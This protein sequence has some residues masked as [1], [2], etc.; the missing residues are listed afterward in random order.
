MCD[1]IITLFQMQERLAARKAKRKQEQQ[2]KPED[3]SFIS[4]S[5]ICKVT[6]LVLRND[7][8]SSE[9][10]TFY[11]ASCFCA[12]KHVVEFAAWYW[13]SK[14]LAAYAASQLRWFL[15]DVMV[16][17]RAAFGQEDRS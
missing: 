14:G 2:L 3:V 15:F 8:D 6:K 1:R 13:V 5:F 4:A 9:F 7:M 11:P 10:D 17:Y 16:T 12:I